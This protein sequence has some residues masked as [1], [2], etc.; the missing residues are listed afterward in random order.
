M[1]V[2]A[3]WTTGARPT[4]TPVAAIGAERYQQHRHAQGDLSDSRYAIADERRERQHAPAGEQE[5]CRAAA[6]DEQQAL[7]DELPRDAAAAGAERRAHRELLR[8][9]RHAR[10]HQIGHVCAGDEQQASDRTE[11]DEQCRPDVAD[12]AIAKRRQR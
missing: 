4:S 8:P 1:S 5:A 3:R 9:R 11:R 6:C 10:E 2:A 7:G 12:L